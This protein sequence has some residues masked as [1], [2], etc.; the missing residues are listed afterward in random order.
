MSTNDNA[1]D[2]TN[3]RRRIAAEVLL[4]QIRALLREAG[5]CGVQPRVGDDAHNSLTGAACAVF[6]ARDILRPVDGMTE[7]LLVLARR[8]EADERSSK[9]T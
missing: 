5:R 7:A 2:A 9:T 1:T 6:A 8:L 4:D 3:D